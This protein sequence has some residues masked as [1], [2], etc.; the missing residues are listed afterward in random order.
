MNQKI[1]LLV[2]SLGTLMAA[3]DTR[4]VLLALPTITDCLHTNLFPSIWVL[5]A[6]LIVLAV[7]ST[8]AGRIGDLIGRGK[9]YNSGFILFTL[10]SALAGISPN[11]CLLISFRVI[12]AI[13]GALLT[14]NSYAIIADV[15]A[16][17]IGAVIGAIFFSH[18]PDRYGRKRLFMIT[19]GT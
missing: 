5:L 6:Y 8:Q 10:A 9:I 18:L 16:Y 4:I 15:S 1:V 3:V 14:S 17:L 19:L 13:G 12:Q 11:V 7:L 2:L